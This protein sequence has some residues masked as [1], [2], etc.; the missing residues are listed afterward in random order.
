VVTADESRRHLKAEG[1]EDGGPCRYDAVDGGLVRMR[2][3]EVQRDLVLRSRLEKGG[4]VVV[5][6]DEGKEE[7]RRIMKGGGID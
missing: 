2:C 4:N 5:S 7:F 1:G 6:P 3:A